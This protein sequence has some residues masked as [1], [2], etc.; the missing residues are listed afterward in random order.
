M[1]RFLRRLRAAVAVAFASMGVLHF[2]PGP[3]A[4]MAA[5]VPPALRGEGR[6]A[7]RLVRFTGACEIAGAAGL[8]HPRT[9]RLAAACLVAFLGAV[10]PANAYAAAHPER[11]GAFAMPLAPR[12]VGQVV[13][14]ALVIAAGAP[15]APARRRRTPQPV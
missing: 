5:M 2:V 4:T 14:A 15:D 6:T 8:L 3:A 12:L 11:F 1:P 10:F 7:A 9:R 13:L